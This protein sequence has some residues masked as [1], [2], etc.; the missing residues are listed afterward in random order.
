MRSSSLSSQAC[1]IARRHDSSHASFSGGTVK[2]HL[3]HIME[4]PGVNNRT[5][6]VTISIRRG[7]I[8]L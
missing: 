2:A 8:H 4:T 1:L 7:I 5:S 6:A 3:K